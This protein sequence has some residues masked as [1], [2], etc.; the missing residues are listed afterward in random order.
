MTHARAFLESLKVFTIA[1]SLGAVESLA[2]SPY[3]LVLT[4][5]CACSNPQLTPLST[6][7]WAVSAVVAVVA[8]TA[9]S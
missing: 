8:C 5:L 7:N 9:P 3:G 6:M 2:E 4:R 1:E